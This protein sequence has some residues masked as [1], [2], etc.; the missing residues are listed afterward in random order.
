M[1]SFNHIFKEPWSIILSLDE[2]QK[3]IIKTVVICLITEEIFHETL[4][5]DKKY[6]NIQIDERYGNVCTIF[7][8]VFK[9][10]GKQ[11][12]LLN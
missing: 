8:H 12:H 6:T 2:E 3:S 10:D 1:L 5:K 4:P 7:A 11:F 9:L